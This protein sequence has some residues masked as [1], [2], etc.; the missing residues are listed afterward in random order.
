MPAPSIPPSPMPP[1]ILPSPSLPVL[2]VVNARF[3]GAQLG[4]NRLDEA[5]VILH[6]FDATEDPHRPWALCSLASECSFLTDRSYVSTSVVYEGKSIAFGLDH[7]G[8]ILNPKF[9]QLLCA[10]NSDGGTRSKAC[11]PPGVSDNCVPGCWA[12]PECWNLAKG[13]RGSCWFGAGVWNDWCHSRGAEG[14]C[15]WHPKDLGEVLRRDRQNV[16]YNELVIDTAT[17]NAH[18]PHSIEA[19]LIGGAMANTR[20]IYA[21][22]RQEYPES[23]APLLRFVPGA[24]D[25]FQLVSGPEDLV[26]A[27]TTPVLFGKETVIGTGY[28]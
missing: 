26:G 6:T 5:G 27:R 3:H 21:D 4:S 19:F 11:N 16:Q 24:H 2:D 13:Q 18:L 22:F 8:V 14:T 20:K 10:Y 1:P 28:G 17:W 25:P 15:A 23:R 12:G 9:A 7:G